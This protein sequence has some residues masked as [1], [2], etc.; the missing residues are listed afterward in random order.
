MSA[1]LGQQAA[2][3]PSLLCLSPSSSQ[4]VSPPTDGISALCW[5]PARAGSTSSFL[6]ATSWD[7]QTRCYEVQANGQSAPRAAFTSDAPVLCA[8]WHHDGASVFSGGCDKQVKRWDLGS[9]AQSQ[10]AAHDAPV[11]HL[12]WIPELSMLVTGGWDRQLRYWDLRQQAPA[13]SHTLPERCYS[14]SVTHPLLVVAT[15]DRHIQVFNLANP[16]VVYKQVQ[17]PLK[18]QTRCV[19]TFPDK[20]GYLVGSIEGRVA[21]QHVEESQ[22]ARNFTFKCHREQEQIYAVNSCA[23]HP[24][25]ATFVTTGSDGCY[26]FWDKDSKQ[27]LKAM[28]KCNA[29]IPCGAFNSDGSIFA[30]AASYDWSKGAEAHNVSTA[31]NAIYLH[32][33]QDTEVKVRLVLGVARVCGF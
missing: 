32:A 16:Q 21:V 5:S 17:S 1:P 2:P 15:A 20:S 9:N 7:Q 23:F 30:Y 24:V 31:Q 14:L 11:R 3:Q 33:T 26:N 27:R 13:F 28:P 25:H 29:P 18:Y 22:A 8:A 19:T 12:A 10:V 4:V 6:V